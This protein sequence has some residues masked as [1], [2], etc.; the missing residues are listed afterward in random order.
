MRVLRDKARV[1]RCNTPLVSP[2]ASCCTF[3][4]RVG[5]RAPPVAADG[6]QARRP[7]VGPGDRPRDGGDHRLGGPTRLLGA[8]TTVV[9][10][11]LLFVGLI[12]PGVEAGRSGLPI[13]LAQ[14]IPRPWLWIDG[15]MLAACLLG[16]GSCVCLGESPYGD[17]AVRYRFTLNPWMTSTAAMFR[18]RFGC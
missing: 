5:L 7:R 4:C 11:V 10:W 3:F 16:Y 8:L 13:V 9:V 2:G 1:Q 17:P 12:L 14:T 6:S 18:V 15:L